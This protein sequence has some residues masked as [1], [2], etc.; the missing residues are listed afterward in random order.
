MGVLGGV[1]D[2]RALAQVGVPDQAEPLEELEVAVDGRRVGGG[3]PGTGL[4]AQPGTDGV[5]GGVLQ[6]R[7]RR[8]HLRALGGQPQTAGPQ[9][10]GERRR[11]VLGTHV[12][13]LGPRSG[14]L[15]P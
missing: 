7:D 8:Q 12:T 2:R 1:V 14:R 11:A 13:S 10:L 15:V 9:P 6:L 5:G 4:L 3:A